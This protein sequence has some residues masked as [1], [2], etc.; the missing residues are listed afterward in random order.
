MSTVD[1]SGEL[2]GYQTREAMELRQ[3]YPRFVAWLE[4][5]GCLVQ[6]PTSKYEVL[7]YRAVTYDGSKPPEGAKAKSHVVYRRADG[8]I[9]WTGA[10]RTHWAWFRAGGLM[11]AQPEI[12]TPKKVKSWTVRTREKLIERDG[13]DCYFCG[14]TMIGHDHTGRATPDGKDDITIEHL[15]SRHSVRT[16]ELTDADVNHI[17]Y[18]VLAHAHC[19]RQIGH[20]PVSEK[21]TYREILHTAAGG[22]GW[23]FDADT[24]DQDPQAR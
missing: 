6:E 1:K 4:V 7:R 24:T 2:S 14:K 8:S 11:L 23:Q 21:L 5:A 9:N 15:L 18:L 3:L 22:V 12:A 17:D 10:S 16:G 20:R 19:N 13:T